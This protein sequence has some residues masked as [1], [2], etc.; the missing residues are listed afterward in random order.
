MGKKTIVKWVF[1]ENDEN[2]IKQY[3]EKISKV[4]KLN[5]YNPSKKYMI[6][7]I[8]IFDDL[9]RF[10]GF[11]P[12]ISEGYSECEDEDFYDFCE[13]AEKALD[14]AYDDKVKVT[15]EDVEN[16]AK[17]TGDN[18]HK[19]VYDRIL[20]ADIESEVTDWVLDNCDL[21]TKQ[22]FLDWVYSD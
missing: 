20:D 7:Y 19:L 16:Y 15:I 9:S 22:K 5:R 17:E 14:A 13:K 2:Q 1:D 10:F 4:F 12:C 6:D 18:I 21:I 11:I 3:S 8:E